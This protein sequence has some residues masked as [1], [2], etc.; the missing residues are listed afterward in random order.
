MVDV[1]WNS[2]IQ[3]VDKRVALEKLVKQ[4]VDLGGL[5]VFPPSINIQDKH[6]TGFEILDVREARNECNN[7]N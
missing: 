7:W 4:V 3:T 2:D 1:S 6:Y 5:K